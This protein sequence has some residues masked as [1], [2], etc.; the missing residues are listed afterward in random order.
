MVGEQLIKTVEG[1]RRIWNVFLFA[2]D[3]T[4]C[5]MWWPHPTVNSGFLLVRG[6]LTVSERP[7]KQFFG[8]FCDHLWLIDGYC[9]FLGILREILRWIT[10]LSVEISSGNDK[11]NFY[12][13]IVHT[14]LNWIKMYVYLPVY[15]Y[16]H[17]YLLYIYN[18]YIFIMHY[19]FIM[20]VMY[21]YQF[22]WKSI[23]S[24]SIKMLTRVR[25]PT[26]VF[27][28]S[29]PVFLPC[30]IYQNCNSLLV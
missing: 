26:T 24:L 10:P 11:W 5:I 22:P 3:Y 23:G 15:V 27:I 14:N 19:I 30:N 7:R 17:V 2:S 28:A 29:Y 8:F 21:I 12:L 18:V 16:L 1:R 25:S 13:E 9:C 20:Y 4:F 6:Y